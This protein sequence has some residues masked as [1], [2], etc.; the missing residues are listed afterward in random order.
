MTFRIYCI[1]R[2]MSDCQFYKYPKSKSHLNCKSRPIFTCEVSCKKV[3]LIIG[4]IRYSLLSC[5]CTSI[6]FELAYSPTPVIRTPLGGGV[7]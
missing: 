2:C 3:G 7:L 1:C 5:A 4:E 6:F